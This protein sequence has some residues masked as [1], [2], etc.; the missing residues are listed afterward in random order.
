MDNH[1]HGLV[2]L[3]PE[4]VGEWSDEEVTRRWG[5]LF[6]PRGLKAE[7]L[8]VSDAWVEDRLK[9][10]EWIFRA[11]ERLSSLS[12]FMKSLK[13]PLSRMVNREEKARSRNSG[14]PRP[15][16]SLKIM[17]ICVRRDKAVYPSGCKSRPANFGRS[18]RKLSERRWR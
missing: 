14:Q 7:V 6:P 2:R 9:H 16:L 10:P 17:N 5:K 13:E 8:E 15:S 18:S 1:L 3:D 12:W 4:R 11:R